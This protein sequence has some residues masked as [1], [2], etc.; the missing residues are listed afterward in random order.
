MTTFLDLYRELAALSRRRTEAYALQRRLAALAGLAAYRAL[1]PRR[2][3]PRDVQRALDA[4]ASSSGADRA[5]QWQLAASALHSALAGRD[6]EE[7]WV[8]EAA[9]RP[10]LDAGLAHVEA[11]AREARWVEH[12]LGELAATSPV[13]PG[14]EAHKIRT[15]YRSTY[16]TQGFGADTYARQAAELYALDQDSTLTDEER[17]AGVRVEVERGELTD[18]GCGIGRSPGE[19]RVV[20]RGVASAADADIV[21]RRVSRQTLVEWVAACWKR[22]TNPRVYDPWLPHGFEAKWGIGYDGSIRQSEVRA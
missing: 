6:E 12:R 17:A 5:W 14:V 2:K 21:R 7:L 16:A 10:A 18:A 4:A 9:M 19:Y 3:L 11:L 22:G 20:V 15:V 1:H 13:A 8:A